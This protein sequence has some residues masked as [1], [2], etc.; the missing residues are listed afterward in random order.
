MYKLI[1]LLSLIAF[2]GC[3]KVK[4]GDFDINKIPESELKNSLSTLQVN[5][6]GMYIY[7]GTEKVAELGLR[8]DGTVVHRPF[9]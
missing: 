4:V 2:A 7:K 6:P 3:T 5:W 1:L 9:R 8:A